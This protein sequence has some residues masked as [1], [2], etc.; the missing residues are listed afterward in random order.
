MYS[1][2]NSINNLLIDR[3]KSIKLSKKKTIFKKTPNHNFVCKST[4]IAYYFNLN[5][6]YLCK[7]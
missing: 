3:R 1:N 7:W 6:Q 5:V 4:L 2:T